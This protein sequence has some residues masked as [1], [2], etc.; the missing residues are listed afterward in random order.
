M[1]YTGIPMPLTSNG[2]N[3]AAMVSSDD[4]W[5]PGTST[6]TWQTENCCLVNSGIYQALCMRR[7]YI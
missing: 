4:K 1:M 6:I 3:C 5:L 2:Y 7:E